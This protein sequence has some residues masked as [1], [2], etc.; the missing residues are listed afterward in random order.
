MHLLCNMADGVLP[1][2]TLIEHITNTGNLTD[3]GMERED[4]GLMMCTF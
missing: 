1:R 4:L 3:V 2:N